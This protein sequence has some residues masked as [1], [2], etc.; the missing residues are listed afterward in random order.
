M[1]TSYGQSLLHNF[2]HIL[3]TPWS[4]ILS[5]G[6][7]WKVNDMWNVCPTKGHM[8]CSTNAIRAIK[9]CLLLEQIFEQLF[10]HVQGVYL[11]CE[12]KDLVTYFGTQPLT[13][14]LGSDVFSCIKSSKTQGCTATFFWASIMQSMKTLLIYF[15]T[16]SVT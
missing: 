5:D 12:A 14:L 4:Y 2:C 10:F 1:L 8:Q 3:L 9:C 15:S 6:K 16:S 7:V 11:S 13:P